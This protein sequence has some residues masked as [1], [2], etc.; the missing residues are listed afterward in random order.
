MF[1]LKPADSRLFKI[2]SRVVLGITLILALYSGFLWY[3]YVE[4]KE[5]TK[6]TKI[7]DETSGG[8]LERRT[9][10][11]FPNKKHGAKKSL[12]VLLTTVT[13]SLPVFLL[14][15]ELLYDY[16]FLRKKD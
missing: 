4:D 5:H 3:G 11:E 6:E 15:S 1:I 8:I 2:F 7:C 12:A 9:C 13:I 16:F 14:I 10:L